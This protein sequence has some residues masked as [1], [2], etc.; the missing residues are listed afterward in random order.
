MQ[1]AMRRIVVGLGLV[2]GSVACPESGRA[3]M[4][5]T[6]SEV[7]GDVV[8]HGSGNLVLTGFPSSS[9]GI[10]SPAIHPVVGLAW[11]GPNSAVVDTYAGLTGPADFGPGNFTFA[12]T[13]SG[14]PFGF[15]AFAAVVYVP[16]G[17][18]SGSP[19]S[20]TATFSGATFAGL[21]LT[22]GTYVYTIQSD[23]ITLNIG[24]TAAAAPEPSSLA[25]IGTAALAGLA[26]TYRR[27][28]SAAFHEP[29]GVK[30][31]D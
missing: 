22:P 16:T 24:G 18:V 17:Y 28:K 15:Y 5:I 8:F 10:L 27:R 7:G 3:A 13:G 25:L 14:D 1:L 6:A 30:P 31:R 23:T 26:W 21:G 20:S 9:G 11:L 19:L 4:I 29:T 12:S 2:V